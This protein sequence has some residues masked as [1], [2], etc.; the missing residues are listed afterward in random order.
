VLFGFQIAA[1]FLRVPPVGGVF[2]DIS[3][4]DQKYNGF[5]KRFAR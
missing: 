2:R 3:A 4:A 1:I 5:L